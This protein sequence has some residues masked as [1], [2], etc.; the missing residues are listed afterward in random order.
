MNAAQE[1]NHALRPIADEVEE[2]ANKQ[3]P[4]PSCWAALVAI[5]KLAL[6]VAGSSPAGT[7]LPFISLVF[8][9]HLSEQGADSPEIAAS[10]LAAMIANGEWGVRCWGLLRTCLHHYKP[11]LMDTAKL[12]VYSYA[13]A[14]RAA[15]SLVVVFSCWHCF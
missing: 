7:I 5:V 14:R 4:F 8:V 15:V 1:H 2:S 3:E 13:M 11:E 10:G 12:R 6:P 9:G